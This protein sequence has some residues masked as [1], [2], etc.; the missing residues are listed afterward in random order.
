MIEGIRKIMRGLVEEVINDKMPKI[1][2]DKLDD[3][4]SEPN[5]Y[6]KEI[7]KILKNFLEP[8]QDTINNVYLVKIL[9]KICLVSNEL[10]VQGIFKNKKISEMGVIQLLCGNKFNIIFPLD[11]SELKNG[12]QRLSNMEGDKVP[13]KIYLNHVNKSTEKTSSIIRLL[14]LD[15]KTIVDQLNN[16]KKIISP[17]EFEKIML[18]KGMKKGEISVIIEQSNKVER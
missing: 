10:F 18:M 8:F 2:W 3:G 7:V 17:Y 14:S 15:Q 13:S 4:I 11:F 9:N 16:F 12:L 6:V 5:Q 1:P